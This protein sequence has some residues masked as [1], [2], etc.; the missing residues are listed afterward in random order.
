MPAYLSRFLARVGQI[1][2]GL[3]SR[4]YQRI[5]NEEIISQIAWICKVSGQNGDRATKVA[6]FSVTDYFFV[7]YEKYGTLSI[8]LN[9]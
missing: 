5:E 9:I 4:F 7:K 8:Y 3:V 2:C 1:W 6:I